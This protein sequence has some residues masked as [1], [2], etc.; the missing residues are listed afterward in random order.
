MYRR[1][2]TTQSV[3]DCTLNKVF[4][5]KF[6]N[7]TILIIALI[8]YRSNY[9][10]LSLTKKNI[11]VF[12]VLYMLAIVFFEY[13]NIS[14]LTVM[15]SRVKKR[16]RWNPTTPLLKNEQS[17]VLLWCSLDIDFSIADSVWVINWKS[18]WWIIFTVYTGI[19]LISLWMEIW[20]VIWNYQ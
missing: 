20:P 14:P 12:Y 13:V 19:I 1:N 2:N 5:S 3:L 16:K 8:Y 18:I 9:K 7:T 6:S 4:I 15:F 10:S 17:H 11:A